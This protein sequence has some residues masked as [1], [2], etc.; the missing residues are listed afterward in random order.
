MPNPTGAPSL[1]IAL[2]LLGTALG[3]LC[4]LTQVLF[5]SRLPS[6][7]EASLTPGQQQFLS[8]LQAFPWP[9]ALP[10]LSP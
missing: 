5:H 8:T 6:L 2:G 9:P 7:A 10:W 4:R 1:S 3:A